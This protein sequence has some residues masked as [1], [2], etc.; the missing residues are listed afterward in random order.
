MLNM[1]FYVRTF[2][3]RKLK[4]GVW[5]L[6]TYRLLKMPNWIFF[7]QYGFLKVSGSIFL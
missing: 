1:T 3:G 6:H 4:F 5:T 7:K 2:R